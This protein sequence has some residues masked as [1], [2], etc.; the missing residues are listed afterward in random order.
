MC[1]HYANF[2]EEYLTDKG[3]IRLYRNL[4]KPYFELNGDR[5]YYEAINVIEEQIYLLYDKRNKPDHRRD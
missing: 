1:K 3:S 2:F 4:E 5:Y